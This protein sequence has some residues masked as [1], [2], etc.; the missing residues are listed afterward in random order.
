MSGSRMVLVL[1][2]RRKGATSVAAAENGSRA[3]TQ[4]A[5]LFFGKYANLLVAVV[6]GQRSRALRCYG[7]L[8]NAELDVR[9]TS[10]E[11]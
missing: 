8:R 2:A 3:S 4:Y 10:V 11:L 1:I 6:C 9:G 5:K 7:S